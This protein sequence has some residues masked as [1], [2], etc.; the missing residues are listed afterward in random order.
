MKVP[1]ASSGLRSCDI[2]EAIATLKSGHLTM[3]QKV[4]LFEQKIESLGVEEFIM[5]DDRQEHLPHFIEWA[6]TQSIKIIVVDVLNKTETII[7]GTEV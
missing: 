6:K 3:G 1:L 2:D 5:F 4:K 7:Q